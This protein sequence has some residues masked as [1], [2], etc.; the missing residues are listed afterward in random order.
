M[1]MLPDL[2][3]LDT[4]L[5][6]I[7]ADASGAIRAWN[8]GAE[9]IFGHPADVALTHRVDLV[10]PPDFRQMHWAGFHRTVGTAWPGHDTWG[11]IE[12]LHRDGSLVALQ[13]LL[14]PMRDGDGLVRGV[15]ALFR[16][17]PANA[18]PAL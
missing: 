13:V 17:Q 6:V 2:I 3:E 7:L 18:G 5:A 11:D 15:L 10:V 14:T 8:Q 12:G 9:A 4:H 1:V 16:K